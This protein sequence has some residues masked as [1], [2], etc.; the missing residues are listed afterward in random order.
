MCQRLIA[1]LRNGFQRRVLG[2]F[3]LP[4][5]QWFLSVFGT[6]LETGAYYR[7]TYYL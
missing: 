2:I 3:L 4:T 5:R 6:V 1:S 7:Y